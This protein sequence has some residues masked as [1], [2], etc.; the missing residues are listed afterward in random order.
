MY[1]RENNQRDHIS[2]N[3]S[4]NENLI[5]RDIV[6]Y[7]NEKVGKNINDKKSIYIMENP[8]KLNQI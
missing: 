1:Q 7:T 2:F 5:P 4:G 3:L 6:S 8:V